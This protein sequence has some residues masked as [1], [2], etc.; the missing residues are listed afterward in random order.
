MRY[1]SFNL[2]LLRE[3]LSKSTDGICILDN[4]FLIKE[5]NQNF[6]SILG[7]KKEE[8]QNRHFF[9]FIS[10]KSEKKLQNIK[11]TINKE[12]KI[13]SNLVF[14]DKNGYSL[15]ENVKISI[16]EQHIIFFLEDS[17]HNRDKRYLENSEENFFQKTFDKLNAAVYIADPESH[18][19][20][21]INK[22]LRKI[23]GKERIQGKCYEVFHNNNSP[24]E[25][26][27][28]EKLIQKGK[29][30]I[31]WEHFNRKIGKWFKC[32]DQAIR[33]SNKKKLRLE[34]AF[35]IT[36]QKLI[37]KKLKSAKKKLE[38]KN[39]I[40]KLLNQRKSKVLVRISHELKTPII[41]I[42]GYSD[43]I[44]EEFN[45][46]LDD[47]L[48][49]YIKNIKSGT[50]KL[51]SLI[52]TITE[53]ILLEEQKLSFDFEEH[54]LTIAIKQCLK[55]LQNNFR[56]RDISIHSNIDQEIRVYFDFEKIKKVIM[57]LLTN[58][59]KYTQQGGDVWVSACNS[60]EGCLIKIRDTGIGLTK[61][62]QNII[63]KKFGKIE[64]YG[65]GWDVVIN[66][67]GLGLYICKKIISRHGGKIWVES[68]GRNQGT[69]FYIS[70]P[71]NCSE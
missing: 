68:K 69:T 39:R 42:K 6:S 50:N 70:L 53:A 46:D 49:D 38:K 31:I 56:L 35:D 54:N 22:E 21:Y 14:I 63:F 58:A 7:Y 66:G 19:I 57:N 45:E 52:D 27:T 48:L 30:P 60:E 47:E 65:K 37:Q 43:L 8:L 4:N 59:L 26:C 40:L 51:I 2:T 5:I 29:S 1:M 18:E 36:E 55:N 10:P 67:I 34:I 32:I 71:I 15:S 62:E 61:N 13:C 64:H 9:S 16:I 25:F 28:N 41:P 12:Q 3:I 20:I 24:C 17:Y 11:R 44:L 33:V 23:L